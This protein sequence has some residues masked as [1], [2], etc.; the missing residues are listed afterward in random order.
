MDNGKEITGYLT[1]T[2]EVPFQEVAER[3]KTFLTSDYAVTL[4]PD[5]QT[6]ASSQGLPR[7][8][9]IIV[10]G[11]NGVRIALVS[12]TAG[13]WDRAP[14]RGIMLSDS[15]EI[16]WTDPATGY[17]SNIRLGEKPENFTVNWRDFTSQTFPG[18]QYV[19]QERI[20]E[21]VHHP[22]FFNGFYRDP[23]YHP[24]LESQFN[25][26]TGV[27]T[28][29]RVNPQTMQAETEKFRELAMMKIL[30]SPPEAQQMLEVINSILTQTSILILPNR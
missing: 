22:V 6:M 13:S 27:L 4:A 8:R 12:K 26:L 18:W 5:Q 17:F 15:L 10:E 24:L 1:A 7:I 11:P 30:D 25:I 2:K 3:V 21:N 14:E 23:Q 9:F 16:R 29:G 28:N 20:E 19:N